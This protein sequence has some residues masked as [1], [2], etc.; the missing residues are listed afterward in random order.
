MRFLSLA[1]AAWVLG[2]CATT[3]TKRGVQSASKPMAGCEA[4]AGPVI[5]VDGA[6]QRQ[7]CRGSQP[8][9]APQCGAGAPLYVIDGVKTCTRP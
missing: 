4:G 2:A 7:S 1:V 3:P 9:P 8:E 5:V 6:V